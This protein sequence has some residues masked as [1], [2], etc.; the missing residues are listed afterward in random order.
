[1]EIDALRT[2]K[3]LFS[4]ATMWL[5]A[6]HTIAA[7]SLTWGPA[8]G[9][10]VSLEAADQNGAYQTIKS[11]TGAKGLLVFFNRSADW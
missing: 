6:T 1:M 5:I 8:H 9:T 3:R 10:V 11:M 4:V 7:E 2:M